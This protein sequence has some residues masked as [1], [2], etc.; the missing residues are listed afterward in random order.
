MG[1]LQDGEGH[2]VMLLVIAW[3]WGVV[4]SRWVTAGWGRVSSYSYYAE[5]AERKVLRL[6]ALL[7]NKRF[8]VLSY[9]AVV[10]SHGTD[11][12]VPS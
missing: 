10:S 7:S 4:V 6:A 1:W 5:V 11:T 3:P 8:R 2:L 9:S 12:V